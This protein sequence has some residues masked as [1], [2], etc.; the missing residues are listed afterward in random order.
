M[1]ARNLSRPAS[2]AACLV[3]LAWFLP[4]CISSSD[5]AQPPPRVAGG[6]L[7]PTAS[8]LSRAGS[9]QQPT[10]ISTAGP[11]TGIPS[12]VSHTRPPAL[13]LADLKGQSE[14][15]RVR[16]VDPI[17]LTDLP[18]YAPFD[19]GRHVTA[20]SPDGRTMAVVLWPG[21]WSSGA[22]LHLIDLVSWTDKTTNVTPI[23]QVNTLVFSPDGRALYWVNPTEH[24]PA[25]NLPRN[26]ELY[27]YDL[28][29][30]T[31][32]TVTKLP[33]SFAP[34]ELR[35][36]RSGNSLAIYGLST[37]AEERAEEPPHV[38]VVELVAG[39]IVAD[40]RLDGI[41]AGQMPIPGAR[42]DEPHYQLYAP[43]TAW[44][45]DHN[46]LYIVHADTD[47]ISVVDLARGKVV[48]QLAI[49]AKLSLADRIWHALV[50]AAAAKG[51]PETARRALLSRD[52]TRLYILGY[53][54]EV[55]KLPNGAVDWQDRPL[56]LQVVATAD[57]SELR[58]RD[59]PIGDMALSS[60]GRWLLLIG[61]G[62]GQDTSNGLYL[63]DAQRLEE[64]AHLQQDGPY[65]L[66]GFS[67]DGRYAYISS[68]FGEPGGYWTSWTVRL[69]VWDLTSQHMVTER[70][71]QGFG[72]LIPVSEP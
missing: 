43:G 66:Y 45:L 16:P 2:V 52:G 13:L 1:R 19:F 34:S 36:L 32:T 63:L 40:V 11:P 62:Y 15:L 12:R 25:H 28:G 47:T 37:D 65:S 70:Q 60:D 46:L 69:Q 35:L 30:Q 3:L 59:A 48:K 21:S 51:L 55:T 68:A 54:S 61:T 5:S 41:K 56:G 14:Q 9:S 64:R 42:G 49:H 53:H 24:D 27:R 31:L 71:F 33:A 22:T 18:D 29:S 38:I 8:P 67:S 57:G 72:E 6:A 4:A 23:D 10:I 20:V 50:P 7:S 17:S 26:F 58:R 39:Q 44:D